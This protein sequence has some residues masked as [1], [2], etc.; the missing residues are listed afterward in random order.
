VVARLLRSPQTA[1]RFSETTVAAYSLTPSDP[2]A[3]RMARRRIAHDPESGYR[4]SE[5]IMFK[6][7]IERD[8]DSK[9]SHPL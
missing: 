2:S 4:F 9:K 8:D 5:K 1:A 7:K 3:A 6:Q